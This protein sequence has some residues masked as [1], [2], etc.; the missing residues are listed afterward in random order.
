[1]ERPVFLRDQANQMYSVSAYF[2]AKTLTEIPITT[3]TPLLYTCIVYV[4]IGYT[5][6]VDQFFT[7]Y[8]I[9]WSLVQSSMALGYLISSIFQDYA[10]ANLV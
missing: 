4:G 1:M 3:L 5:V 6:T 9:L 7:F 10:T 8:L 2:N